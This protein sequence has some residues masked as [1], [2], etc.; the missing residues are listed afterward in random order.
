MTAAMGDKAGVGVSHPHT[1]VGYLKT[2]NAGRG[3]CLRY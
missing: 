2:E 1:P 3:P